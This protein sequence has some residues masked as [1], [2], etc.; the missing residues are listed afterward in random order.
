MRWI[1][2]DSYGGFGLVIPPRGVFTRSFEALRGFLY[3]FMCILLDVASRF[4]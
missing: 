4:R 1:L 3:L 2:K